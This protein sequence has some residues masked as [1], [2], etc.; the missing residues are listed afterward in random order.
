M[1]ITQRIGETQR[2]TDGCICKILFLKHTVTVNAKVLR[3][4]QVVACSLTWTKAICRF[5]VPGR[6]GREDVRDHDHDLVNNRRGG[7]GSI[8]GMVTRTPE[9]LL[10]Q[11]LP[12]YLHRPQ[13][14]IENVAVPSP[15]SLSD[16]LMMMMQHMRSTNKTAKVQIQSRR[17]KSY[18]RPACPPLYLLFNPEES[19]AQFCRM[20][21]SIRRIPRP[22]FVC[23]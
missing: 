7:N 13:H 18:A 4:I 20:R 9:M 3:C 10:K 21:V 16:S 15:Q 19:R 23:H 1:Q 12:K 14:V 11:T 6:G 22:A 5:G 8:F 2:H 17:N